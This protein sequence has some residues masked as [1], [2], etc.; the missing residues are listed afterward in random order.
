L[1]RKRDLIKRE[2]ESVFICILTRREKRRKAKK[3]LLTIILSLEKR[4]PERITAR[5]VG[6][7][8]GELTP[9]IA[10][11]SKEGLLTDYS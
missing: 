8:G 5:D 9:N 6:G 4:K 10:E 11:I 3:H 7:T 2:W 1:S